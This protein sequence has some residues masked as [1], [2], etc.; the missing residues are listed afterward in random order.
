MKKFELD[1]TVL[2]FSFV[3]KENEKINEVLSQ[4]DYEK[5]L[6]IIE[7][8]KKILQLRCRQPDK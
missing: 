7:Y 5:T 3:K 4:K 1:R 6:S 2:L 8:L